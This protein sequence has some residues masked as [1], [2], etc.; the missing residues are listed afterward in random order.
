MRFADITKT[1]GL[2]FLNVKQVSGYPL[3]QRAPNLA[4]C[5]PID[6]NNDG[7]V[8][9]VFVDR[10]DGLPGNDPRLRPW[11]FRNKG[12][13]SFERLVAETHGLDG[14]FNDLSFADFDSDGHLDLVFVHGDP[15]GSGKAAIYRNASTDT[16]H[17]I[18]LNVSSPGNPLGLESK[19]TL[20]KA[21]TRQVI[22]YDEVRTDFCYRSKKSS[23]LHFGLGAETDVDVQVRTRSG[24]ERTFERLSGNQVHTLRMNQP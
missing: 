22:G 1:S 17:W 11:V 5:A 13:G 8:D 2:D 6:F 7:H 15:D 19:V 3:T 18:Q 23:M 4:A 9:L 21:G 24:L 10:Q 12:N 16:N 14:H 20:Y